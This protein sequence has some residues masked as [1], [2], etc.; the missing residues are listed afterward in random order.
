MTKHELIE[1]MGNARSWK[2][3]GLTIKEV[4]DI[5]EQSCD[6][7]SGGSGSEEIQKLREKVDRLSESNKQLRAENRALKGNK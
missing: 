1:K 4:C 2:E 7:K 5:L 6:C 3:L